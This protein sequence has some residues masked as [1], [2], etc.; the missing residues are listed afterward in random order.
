MPSVVDNKKN[1]IIELFRFIFAT[2]IIFYHLDKDI[3]G[4]ESVISSIG[5]ANITFFSNGFIGVEFFFMLTGLFMAQRIYRL[6]KD[7]DSIRI[8]EETFN[9]IIRKAKSVWPIFAVVAIIKVILHLIL[10]GGMDW[11]IINLPSLF[12]LQRTGLCP[13]A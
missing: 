5:N 11:V 13:N 3:L 1:T 6:D 4:L 10:G 8:G 7:N 9:Y 12:F 2:Y